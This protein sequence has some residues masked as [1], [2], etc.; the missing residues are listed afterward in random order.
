MRSWTGAKAY[1]APP[2]GTLNE[3]HWRALVEEATRAARPGELTLN[4]TVYLMKVTFASRELYVREW[5]RYREW[6]P[7]VETVEPTALL[8]GGG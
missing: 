6:Y 2:A 3:W 4:G 7:A 5:A 1:K 8:V